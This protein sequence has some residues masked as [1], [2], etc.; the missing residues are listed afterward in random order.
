MLKYVVSE[1]NCV[2]SR[3]IHV[4]TLCFLPHDLKINDRVY[5]AVMDTMF[6]SWIQRVTPRL[7]AGLWL[8]A[9]DQRIPKLTER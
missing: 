5:F 8:V 4:K 3:E 2:V 9:H 1:I 7:P 6:K